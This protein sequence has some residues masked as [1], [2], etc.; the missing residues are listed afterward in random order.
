MPPVMWF[1]RGHM[2]RHRGAGLS[3]PQF[4]ILALLDRQPRARQICV[5]E[6]LGC[7]APTASRLVTGLVGKGLVMRRPGRRDHRQVALTLTRRGRRVLA[8]SH[9]HTRRQLA[10]QIQHLSDAELDLIAR[11]MRLLRGVFACPV[12][13]RHA[14]A[15][16]VPAAAEQRG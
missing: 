3:V 11:A 2:R 9:R 14:D 13:A 15:P 10:A 16:A 12:R 1:I 5:C 4:R 6:H 8:L 7:T